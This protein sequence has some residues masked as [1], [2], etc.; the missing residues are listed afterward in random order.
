MELIDK[1][2]NIQHL[3]GIIPIGGQPLE[4]NMPWHNCLMPIG[5]DYLAIEKAVIQCAYAGCETIWIV[6][7][8]GTQPL[9]RKRVG[10]III[11]PIKLFKTFTAYQQMK[12][13]SVYY[14]P[15]HPKDRGKRDCLGWSVLY[16]ADSA[17]RISKFISKWI[18]P[19]KFFC[20]FP[21]GLVPD[22]I[23]HENRLLLSSR[24]NVLF[25]YD[26]KTV[27][28]NI[29]APFTFDAEDFFRCRDIVKFKQA[30]EWG[31]T[32]ARFYD[33][34]TVFKGLDSTASTVVNLPWFHDISTWTGYTNYM[35]SEQSKIL[36]KSN[37]LFKGNRRKPYE[38]NNPSN[39]NSANEGKNIEQE[40][41][42][43]KTQ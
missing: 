16:G 38:R 35:A 18:A 42:T 39:D 9:V 22:E 26:G 1:Q 21:Y 2:K 19:E 31:K 24:E 30:A 14:V 8:L 4:F 36:I 32:S 28:D 41:G 40:R 17:F 23:L 10:D 3:A 13:I 15:I 37:K 11:D 5:P 7:H 6:G 25:S 12:E 33:L 43:E 29:H 20:S 27:K 34:A